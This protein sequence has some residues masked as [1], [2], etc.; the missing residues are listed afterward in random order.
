MAKAE[1]NRPMILKPGAGSH[2]DCGAMQTIFKADG[3]ETGDS[4]SV[5]EWWL[6]PGA[7]GPGAHRHDANDEIFFVIAGTPRVLV[8]ETWHDAK[9]GSFMRIPAGVTHDFDNPGKKRAGLFNVF[10]P[11]GFEKDMPNIVAWFGGGFKA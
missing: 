8:G 3:V 6:D 11:G 9:P 4:Y 5:S 2:Y 10:I 7:A 1:R